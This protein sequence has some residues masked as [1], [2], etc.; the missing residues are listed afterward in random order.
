LNKPQVKR[1]LDIL[2]HH[3]TLENATALDEFNSKNVEFTREHAKAK[4][5]VKFLLTLDR[6]FRNL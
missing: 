1:I 3:D 5:F 4:D 2:A 6:Q